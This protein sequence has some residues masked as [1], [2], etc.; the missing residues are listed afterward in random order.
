MKASPSFIILLAVALTGCSTEHSKED[1][2]LA[3][4]RAFIQKGDSLFI[5]YLTG[6]VEQARQGLTQTIQLFEDSNVLDP[7]IQAG[8]LTLDYDR[9]YV[10]EKRT[11]NISSAVA[12]LINAHYWR[13]MELKLNN[14]SDEEAVDM[15]RLDTSEKIIKRVD[16]F[17]KGANN[18][19]LPKFYQYITN[20][21]SEESTNKFE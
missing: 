17:D 3:E 16:D 11:G 4:R 2:K 7:G 5:P 20:S 8:F 12:A 10:L 15:I 6:N 18:G 9:L 21:P 14:F 1:A 19:N 13:F